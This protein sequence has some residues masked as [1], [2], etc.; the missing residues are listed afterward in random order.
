MSVL[1][2]KARK[3]LIKVLDRATPFKGLM[4]VGADL[5]GPFIVDQFTKHVIERY[6]EEGYHDEV[7]RFVE[8]LDNEDLV[9]AE[10]ELK[11]FAQGVVTLPFFK[12]ELAGKTF[13]S[14]LTQMILA[15]VQEIQWR[16]EHKEEE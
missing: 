2:K 13:I 1:T 3:Y 11:A 14:G 5:A 12:N 15:A 10:V 16:I 6:V 8:A 9:A 7:S 4:E